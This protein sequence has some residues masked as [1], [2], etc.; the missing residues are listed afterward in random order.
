[1]DILDSCIFP[2]HEEF[3][4]GIIKTTAAIHLSVNKINGN[5]FSVSACPLV[6]AV[7]PTLAAGA[8]GV[9]VVNQ[10][11]PT[12]AQNKLKEAGGGTFRS[13]AQSH[14]YNQ[15][16]SNS[17]LCYPKYCFR[18]LAYGT[19]PL[20]FITQM[21]VVAVLRYQIALDCK[22]SRERLQCF[23]ALLNLP[24]RGHWGKFS[25]T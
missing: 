9:Q 21:V 22:L 12:A 1:M 24:F 5:W 10:T 15:S 4:S 13:V 6:P 23:S 20:G 19:Q 18:I 14:K 8:K 3:F 17:F 11:P 7:K 25:N 16:S 2:K